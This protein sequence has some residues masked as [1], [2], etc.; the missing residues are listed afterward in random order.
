MI[1]RPRHRRR[2]MAEAEF[3]QA[4]QEAF[5]LLAAKNPEH[6]FRGVGGA[7]ARHHGQNEAGEISMIEVGD[8][9][10][11]QPFCLVRAVPNSAHFRSQSPFVGGDPSPASRR[12]TRISWRKW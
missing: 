6:E 3:F 1:S 11:S 5:L 12:V 10:P 4:G 7:A 2:Q 8:A 9:A